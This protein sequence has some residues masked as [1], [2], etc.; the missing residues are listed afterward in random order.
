MS[1]ETSTHTGRPTLTS[2]A[3]TAVVTAG[4]VALLF[5]EVDL[6]LW[7]ALFGTAGAACFAASLHLVSTARMETVTGVLASL[8]TV[9]VGVGFLVGT[10]GTVLVLVGSFFPVETTGQLVTRSLLL[11]SQVGV[12]VGCLFAVLGVA[13]GVRNVVDGSTLASYFWLTVKTSLVPAVAGAAMVVGAY[14][15]S[16]SQPPVLLGPLLAGV[17]DW[18]LAPAPVTTHLGTLALLVAVAALSVRAAIAALPVAEL[19]ADSGGGETEQRRVEGVRR[20]LTWTAAVGVV[21]AIPLAVLEVGGGPT[22]LRQLVGPG[23][24]RTLVELSTAPPLRSVLVGATAVAVP[25]VVAT[26]L[27]R[28]AARGSITGFLSRIGPFVGGAVVTAVAIAVA[29]SVVAWLVASI[30]AELPTPFETA[31]R[32]SVTLY[33]DFFGA[34]TIVVVLVALL[35]G[36]TAAVVLVG[37][38]ALLAGYLSG[39]TAGY[40]LASGGLFVAAT[41]AGTVDAPA[42][43]VFGGLV[44]AFLVWDVGRYGTTL[45][46]EIGRRAPTRNAELVHAGGTL[47]VGL[48]GTVLAYGVA[49]TIEADIAADSPTAVVALMGVLA[50]IVFLVAALR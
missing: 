48:V 19:L 43:L 35:V 21:G 41:F 16:G 22:D 50:G 28:R 15:T 10:V 38:L 26:R 17:G 1:T 24:Y 36:V 11:L 31:F 5:G 13:V 7:P 40:S 49:T 34:G 42:W 33:T 39:E 46:E 4:L 3:I 23:L 30:A 29:Q 6:V 14:L 45:G 32:E 8:L 12:V 2:T 44:G 37:R 9:A 20:A 27:L 47:A 18:L 25:T